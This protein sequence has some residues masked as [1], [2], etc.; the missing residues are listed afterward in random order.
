MKKTL[1]VRKE[2]EQ[3]W[4]RAAEI[5]P[6]SLAHVIAELLRPWVA[7]QEREIDHL[8]FDRQRLE[9]LMKENADLRE[10]IDKNRGRAPLI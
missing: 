3:I 1:Y 6:S 5:A 9:E 7:Q 4:K 10:W 2:D 8:R